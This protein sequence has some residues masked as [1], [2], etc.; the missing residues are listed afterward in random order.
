MADHARHRAFRPESDEYD[1]V[2]MIL[3][4][5]FKCELC[6][7][8]GSRFYCFPS[9][10]R[11][12]DLHG[13]QVAGPARQLPPAT[14][15]VAAAL[16]APDRGHA[17]RAGLLGTMCVASGY[18][19]CGVAA[20]GKPPFIAIP[21]VHLNFDFRVMRQNRRVTVDDARKDEIE[22]FHGVLFD[23]SRGICSQRVRDY[24]V[25]ACPSFGGARVRPRDRGTLCRFP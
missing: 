2:H 19:S 12:L 22:S 18:R 9:G 6:G 23:V 7:S 13:S 5:D 15:S 4:G 8:A 11:R 3:F 25:Q 16:S 21:R 20:V 14:S 10:V 1:S 24:L 17:R